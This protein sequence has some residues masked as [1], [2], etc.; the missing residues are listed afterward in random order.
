MIKRDKYIYIY[1]ILSNHFYYCVRKIL[2]PFSA[3]TKLYGCPKTVS[4]NRTVLVIEIHRIRLGG[5]KI[6]GA[7]SAVKIHS[8]MSPGYILMSY[9]TVHN[10]CPVATILQFPR[11]LGI[12]RDAS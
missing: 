9:N 3:H 8:L 11:S 5:I 7:D 12:R 2:F 6:T 1:N 10:A 4:L